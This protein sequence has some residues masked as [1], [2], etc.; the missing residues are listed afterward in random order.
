LK[1]AVVLFHKNI[2]RYPP[3]WI[4]ACIES[5]RNQTY[6]NFHVFELDYGGTKQQIYKGSRHM[7]MVL[8]NHAEALNLLLDHV[9]RLGYDCAF[10]VNV[11]DF[12]AAHR[13]E[14]QIEYIKAGYDIVSSNFHLINED[15]QVI[16]SQEM[17]M[18]DIEG[19]AKEGNNIIAHPVICYSKR[20]RD[21]LVPCE[22]PRDDFELW[23]RC[24]DSKKY[25]FIILPDYQLYYRVHS[26]KVS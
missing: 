7:S 20:F 3:Q 19:Q 12:Y 2:D 15:G 14:K 9:F 16:K 5:I 8:N 21:K 4:E 17:H 22:I 6:Q 24:Y 13:F 26:F 1:A 23:K 18:L 11:D 25:K 10:N